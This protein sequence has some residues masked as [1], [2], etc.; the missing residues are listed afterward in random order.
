MGGKVKSVTSNEI[1]HHSMIDI[2]KQAFAVP[3]SEIDRREKEW[4]ESQH[5]RGRPKKSKNTSKGIS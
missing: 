3:K 5:K 4:Q 2:M 1:T